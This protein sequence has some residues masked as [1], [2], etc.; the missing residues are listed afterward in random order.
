MKRWDMPHTLSPIQIPIRRSVVTLLLDPR[1]RI[2]FERLAN[3]RLDADRAP[4][5]IRSI[6]T[7]RQAVKEGAMK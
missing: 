3:V 6:A 5:Y 7:A 1:V 4:L 2:I